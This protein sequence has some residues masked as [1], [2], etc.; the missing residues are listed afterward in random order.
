MAPPSGHDPNGIAV[1]L[2]LAKTLD[3]RWH[4][5]IGDPSIGG[6]ATVA[7]YFACAVLCVRAC[8]RTDIPRIRWFWISAVVALVL[9]GINKQLDLQTW[10]T[11]LG[12]RAAV[13]G[14]WYEQRAIVQQAFIA[15]VGILGAGA[16]LIASA[17]LRAHLAQVWLALVGGG[18]LAA[19]VLIRA[20]SFHHVDRLLGATFAGLPLN[21]LLELGGILAVALAALQTSASATIK[22]AT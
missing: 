20:M 19:F 21:W 11:E 12:R 5:G 15:L 18:F 14:G 6:W 2:I 4:P 3:G 1:V 13:A 9:L 22:R 16:L 17:L 7:A 8:R 10:F